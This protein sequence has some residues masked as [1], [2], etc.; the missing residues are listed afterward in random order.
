MPRSKKV[1]TKKAVG[2]PHDASLPGLPA[3]LRNNIYH[4]VAKDIDEVTFIGRKIG[5]GPADAKDR[6]W[7]TVAKHPLNHTC[8]QLRLDFDAIHRHKSMITGVAQ[9]CLEVENYDVDRLGDFARLLEQVPSVLA[10]VQ[11]CVT[12]GKPL[13]RFRLNN[14]VMTFVEKVRQDLDAPDRLRTPFMQLRALLLEGSISRMRHDTARFFWWTAYGA[15]ST[16]MMKQNMSAIEKKDA[17][18]QPREKDARDALNAICASLSTDDDD[19]G[20]SDGQ[21]AL[22]L[23]RLHTSEHERLNRKAKKGKLRPMVR[24]EL[25]EEIRDEVEIK[26]RKQLKLP[27]KQKEV[28]RMPTAKS[29]LREELK[30]ELKREL[31]K[32]ISGDV[33]TE[34][35]A[36][37]AA[38]RE[39]RRLKHKETFRAELRQE[40]KAELITEIRAE[41][42]AEV[43]A[44]LREQLG[45]N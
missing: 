19:D 36:R 7:D 5:F 41:V 1:S 14:N 42:R 15:V 10:F 31:R 20:N 17:I 35:R 23:F 38:E 39:A 2:P 18:S 4:L 40:L 43:E 13:V 9:Y 32:E 11:S 28:T 24:A 6:L 25:T 30:R 44:E 8:R 26:V 34:I 29:N 16:H 45:M 37:F 3:E 27:A 12:T 21:Y 22:V 33:E